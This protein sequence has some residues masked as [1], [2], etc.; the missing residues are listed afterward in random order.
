MYLRSIMQCTLPSELLLQIA[1]DY[2]T[3][4]YIYDAS[5]INQQYKKLT[6]AFSLLPTRIFY[7]CKALTNIHILR[8]INSLGCNIDCSSINEVKLALYAGVS[9][10]NILYTSN[11]V[12]FEEI[13][14]AVEAGVHVLSLIHI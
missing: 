8:Y 6:D 11:G 10:A 14:E 3:P 13:V 1:R 5:T 7:A 4:V 12:D 2:G 9:P